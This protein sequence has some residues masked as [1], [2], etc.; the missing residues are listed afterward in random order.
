[1]TCKEE[2]GTGGKHKMKEILQ[3]LFKTNS[4]AEHAE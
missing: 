1:M 4:S 3:F 2:N